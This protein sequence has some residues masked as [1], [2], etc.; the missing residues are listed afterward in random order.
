VYSEALRDLVPLSGEQLTAYA[1]AVQLGF[2]E[3]VEDGADAE[4]MIKEMNEH[5][6]E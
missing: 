3:A 2:W 4:R 6:S 1:W 5:L